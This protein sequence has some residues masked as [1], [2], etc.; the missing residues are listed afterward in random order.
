[1]TK[2]SPSHIYI[3]EAG[4][5]FFF[6]IAVYCFSFDKKKTSRDLFGSGHLKKERKSKWKA[7]WK[8][9]KLL[10]LSGRG[11]T[12]QLLCLS[13]LLC[14]VC[15]SI[16]WSPSIT[17]CPESGW[18]PLSRRPFMSLPD[19]IWPVGQSNVFFCLLV[20]IMLPFAAFCYSKKD[21]NLFYQF[22]TNV[23]F[24]YRA[25]RWN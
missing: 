4:V 25:G 19:V 2:I 14:V 8:I 24:N 3:V 9:D 16:C 10:L 15:V 6:L 13:L 22:K 12:L 5:N 11:L 17:H 23:I 1:M 20:F 21:G 18:V 7:E